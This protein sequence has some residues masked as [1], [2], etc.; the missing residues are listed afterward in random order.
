MVIVY[1]EKLIKHKS[2][3]PH[4]CFMKD[5]KVNKQILALHPNI[6][7]KKIR[8]HKEYIWQG[9]SNKDKQKYVERSTKINNKLYSVKPTSPY[10]FFQKDKNITKRI[11]ELHPEARNKIGV[12][13]RLRARMWKSLPNNEY[14]KYKMES[15]S[16]L[17]NNHFDKLYICRDVCNMILSYVP[18]D[19]CNNGFVQNI[20][21]LNNDNQ[22]YCKTCVQSHIKMLKIQ[23]MGNYIVGDVYNFLLK[24]IP[25]HHIPQ[26]RNMM[27]WFYSN[28]NNRTNTLTKSIQYLTDP[29][30]KYTNECRKDIDIIIQNLTE[31]VNNNNVMYTT[32]LKEHNKQDKIDYL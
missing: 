24:S 4:S 21:F 31:L 20:Y 8:E 26:Q 12:M 28:N 13:S 6:T 32:L 14:Q 25:S 1:F 29:N 9:L 7:K 5:R 30:V 27:T 2:V 17:R 11:L 18:C 16:Q 3:S 10:R 22:K 19:K 15:I 23:K